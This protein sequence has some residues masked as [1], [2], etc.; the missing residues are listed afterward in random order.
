M[1]RTSYS[2]GYGHDLRREQ[3]GNKPPQLMRAMIEFFTKPSQSV[4]DPFCGVGGT[5]IGAALCGR[6]ATGIELNPRWLDI[7]RQV[8]E[9]EKIESQETIQ[10]DCLKALPKLA[11]AGRVFDCIATDPPYSI[12]LDKTM[13]DGVYDLQHR[14]TDFDGYSNSR[15]DFRNLASFDEYYDAMERAFALM[16]P[17]LRA[18]GY[19]AV[20]M[21]DSYQNGE[22]IPA[23]YEV[24]ERIRRGGFTLK[25][26][27]IWYGTGA[28]VRPYGYPYAYVPNIVHQS[29]LVLRKET[30]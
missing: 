6:K 17:L 25:G 10:G 13:C 11:E 9:R 5:L 7:Y 3:G 16:H 2:H 27:R 12:A 18:G 26:I 20:I 8:C 1:L 14:K 19:L 24:A 28:R 22:Y 30:T 15:A 29:I 21:R 4:L 23:S